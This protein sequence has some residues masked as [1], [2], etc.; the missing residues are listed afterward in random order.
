M[1]MKIGICRKKKGEID[2]FGNSRKENLGWIERHKEDVFKNLTITYSEDSL[3]SS[4][5]L[6]GWGAAIVLCEDGTWFLEDT[7]GG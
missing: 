5:H 6:Q 3:Y 2:L 7:T 4:L 1:E